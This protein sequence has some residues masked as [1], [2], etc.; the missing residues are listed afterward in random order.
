V[1]RRD[2]RIGKINVHFPRA[3]A[4]KFMARINP[5][6]PMAPGRKPPQEI[7]CVVIGETGDLGDRQ[8]AVALDIEEP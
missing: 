7:G 2:D 3:G 8:E 5:D 1:C 6:H 4:R